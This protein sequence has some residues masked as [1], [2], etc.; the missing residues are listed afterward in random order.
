M[1]SQSASTGRAAETSGAEAERC[2]ND[3]DGG[4]EEEADV[5]DDLWKEL[6]LAAIKRRRL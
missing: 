3:E 2:I 5:T 4:E 6:V 1:E